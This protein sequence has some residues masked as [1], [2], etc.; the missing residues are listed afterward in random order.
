MSFGRPGG[1]AAALKVS[2]P[3]RGSFPLDHDGE[4]K[5]F[6]LQYLQCLKINQSDNGQ[7]RLESKRYL[8]CRME[9]G[10]MEKDDM[11]NL[12][13]GDVTDPLPPPQLQSPLSTPVTSKVNN[14]DK[15]QRI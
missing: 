12:G 11:A 13:L 9:K 8:L 3:D 10:L 4:C 14:P 2:P 1:F 15:M 5:N 7:C 6:M